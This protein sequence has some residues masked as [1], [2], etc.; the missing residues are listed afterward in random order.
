[1][2]RQLTL[3]GALLFSA[4]AVAA[5]PV[6]DPRLIAVTPT[7]EEFQPDIPWG[8]RVNDIA[9][10]PLR[11][12]ELLAATESGGL[13]RSTDSGAHW[14]HVDGLPCFRMRRVAYV[15][16]EGET[17]IATTGRDFKLP[18]GGGIWRSVDGGLTWE[19]PAGSVPPESPKC[20]ARPTAYGLSIAPD[21]GAL[22]VATDCGVSSSDDGGAS[23]SHVEIPYTRNPSDS[24]QS[25]FASVEALG[26]GHVLLGGFTGIWY[27]ADGGS[28]WTA[29]TPGVGQVISIRAFS[30]S[31]V[32][33]LDAYVVNRDTRLF[34]SEDAG[35]SWTPIES[36]PGGWGGC[37]GIEFVQA[38]RPPFS[39]LLPSRR[40]AIELYYGNR[41]D[42]S[43]LYAPIS[44]TTGR[45]DYGGTWQEMSADHSDARVLAFDGARW[46]RY[47]GT[48]GG[49]HVTRD[50]GRNFRVSG[51]GPGGLNALQVTE[52]AGQKVGDYRRYDLYFATQDNDLWSSTDDGR[53]WNYR[54]GAE[55][56]H[57]Q[58][59]RHVSSAAETKVTYV[60]CAG[61]NTVMSD[62]NFRNQVDWPDP[63][64]GFGSPVFVTRGVHIQHS[65]A[66][67]TSP[68]GESI[69]EDLG[70]SWRQFVEI[71][72]EFRELPKLS[73]PESDP[74][75]YQ[76][77]RTG[78]NA[79]GNE[80]ISLARVSDFLGSPSGS[81]TYPAMTGFSGLGTNPT[82]FAW[83]KV[84]G[85]DPT[86]PMHLIAP[87]ALEGKL[88]QSW[89]GGETWREMTDLT[90]F[91]THRG[92]L[93]FTDDDPYTTGSYAFPLVTAVSFCPQNPN[94]VLLGTSEGGIYFSKDRGSA[95][96]RIAGSE[97]ATYVTSF[98]W[99]SDSSAI[100]STYG[101][102]LWKVRLFI[103]PAI[104]AY[105]PLCLGSCL[106]FDPRFF[107]LGPVPQL[108]DVDR[109]LLVFDGRIESLRA[110]GGVLRSVS[111]D[112][113]AT[114]LVLSDDPKV[115][116]PVDD[117]GRRLPFAFAGLPA[118]RRLQSAGLVLRGLAL[119]GDSIR[120]LVASKEVAQLAVPGPV[121]PFQ[122]L[123][124]STSGVEGK[125]YLQLVS[126]SVMDG[127]PLVAFG[128]PLEI[129]GRN[130]ALDAQA[131]IEI[132]LDGAPVKVPVAVN[133]DGS[134]RTKLVP[135]ALQVGAHQV[136]V[137]QRLDP[138]TVLS[139]ASSFLLIHAEEPGEQDADRGDPDR[140][141]D[142][143]R[144]R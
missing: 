45:P 3:A 139:D 62:A 82:M 92:A 96:E 35:A 94:F 31:P 97:R 25:I 91:I 7:I 63:Q 93:T 46:P 102:G 44:P 89:D 114:A 140:R 124:K 78:V 58:L 32:R 17:V 6:L 85:V 122:D 88:K 70:A 65:P 1:M 86:D 33:P 22:Y 117:S 53:T 40:P 130:F 15:D 9:V 100:V 19:K 101:R 113:G 38:L 55:G 84:F 135:G 119:K 57:L 112:P 68:Q 123:G 136:R 118:V 71:P 80:I 83:Y 76:A 27:S 39:P 5:Q 34:V 87:D 138:Q 26:G 108:V 48:D 69:T 132:T 24:A 131:P 59:E 127:T 81:L 47:L 13:F 110:P 111:V 29:S 43:R 121:V 103:R 52:V 14:T 107:Q 12:S 143:R 30:R 74:V 129:Q 16:A 106:A 18:G 51:S 54:T 64:P 28:S 99:E 23:W 133:Q 144:H 115:T 116:L 8:G 90:D 60:V 137:L 75:F 66:T 37:G 67:D 21:S 104:D 72:E 142:N 109:I 95:W 49:F 105:Q 11:S 126:G 2:T 61:C 10:H 42:A 56:F 98:H 134:F 141:D 20:L 50:G 36:A 120:Y 77:V 125:P 4:V 73:G 128:E 79:D 41:C